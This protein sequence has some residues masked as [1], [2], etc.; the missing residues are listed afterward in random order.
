MP[1]LLTR[2][3]A[4]I[5]LLIGWLDAPR[6]H[7][8]LPVCVKILPNVVVKSCL[9]AWGTHDLS[10][11]DQVINLKTAPDRYVAGAHLLAS[12]SSNKALHSIQS[13]VMLDINLV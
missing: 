1:L 12:T 5:L 6:I 9:R 8:A 2:R 13:V 11:K 10:Q 7:L 4:C 3:Q